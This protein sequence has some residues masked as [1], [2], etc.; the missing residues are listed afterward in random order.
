MQGES[1]LEAPQRHE[2]LLENAHRHGVA[3]DNVLI[4]TL[5]LLGVFNV[6]QAMLPHLLI[7][8]HGRLPTNIVAFN[9][10]KSLLV[11][12]SHLLEPSGPNSVS[13]LSVSN[14]TRNQ[15]LSDGIYLVLAME[16]H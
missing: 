8:N 7:H 5:D 10:M 12:W 9:N 3:H 14:D 11:N 4:H 2:L 13:S 15:A 1:V 16:N 6:S